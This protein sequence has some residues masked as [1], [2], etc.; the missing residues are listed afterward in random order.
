MSNQNKETMLRWYDEVW[1]NGN[2]NVIDEIMHPD[3][4]AYGLDAEPL[5]GP[6]GFKPFYKAFNDAYSDINVTVEKLFVDGD[7]VIALCAV[8]ATHKETGKPVNFTGK[9]IA[10]MEN[11]QIKLAWNH[12]DFLTLNLQTGKIKEEQLV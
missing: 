2:E 8:K 5:I 1:N 10:L 7:H 6:S 9:L 3:A 11:G 12:F 4:K